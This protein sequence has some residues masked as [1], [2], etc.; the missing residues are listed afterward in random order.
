MFVAVGYESFGERGDDEHHLV[1]VSED[2]DKL[3]AYVESLLNPDAVEPGI[4][5][6]Y[7]KYVWEGTNFYHIWVDGPVKVLL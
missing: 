5:G 6:S 4:G 3:E 1:A 7:N 2:K